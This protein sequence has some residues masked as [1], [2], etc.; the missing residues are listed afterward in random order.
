MNKCIP[1]FTRSLSQACPDASARGLREVESG[2]HV[3]VWRMWWRRRAGIG[4]EEKWSQIYIFIVLHLCVNTL[5]D[6]RLGNSPQAAAA[7]V[8]AAAGSSAA[9]A[10]APQSTRS[11]SSRRPS[12]LHHIVSGGD[13][14][15]HSS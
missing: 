3:C 2:D 8:V 15:R 6:H 13:E 11:T 7:A 12:L 4:R 5:L 14:V 10:A 1:S 9:V